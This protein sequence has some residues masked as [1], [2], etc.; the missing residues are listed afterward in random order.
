MTRTGLLLACVLGLARLVSAQT[1][2]PISPIRPV[3][4]SYQ[5]SVVTP[6][7]NGT[8]ALPSFTF[9]AEQNSG[10]YRNASTD[11][12]MSVGGNDEQRWFQNGSM[13][14][15]DAQFGFANSTALTT[16]DT[17]LTRTAAGVFGTGTMSLTTS[18]GDVTTT[19]TGDFTRQRYQATITPATAGATNCGPAFLA[20]ALTADCTIATLPAG[21]KLTAV[22]ADVTVGFTCSGTCTGTKVVQ[23]GTAAGGT[24]ILAASL[25]VAATGQFGLADADLG[26]GMTRAAAIQGGLI[27]SWTATTP[28]SC[29]FTSGTGNWGNASATFVNAGS[30]KFTLITEQIK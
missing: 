7:P 16:L 27:G 23:C 14:R 11:I 5:L 10:F 21:M 30:I 28:V 17:V 13:F 2:V 12:R 6:A 24:Q 26:S 8:A 20:A 15:S 3:I 19:S 22:Y 1:S 18:G 25:N 4:Q 29:R 9:A